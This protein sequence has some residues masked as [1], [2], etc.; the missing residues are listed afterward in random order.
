M[1]KMMK[2]NGFGFYGNMDE[3]NSRYGNVNGNN[4]GDITKCKYYVKP[5]NVTFADIAGLE[6]TK[7]EILEAID[8]FKTL[9][10]IKKWVYIKL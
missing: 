5:S 4:K 8:L 7:E 2:E 9:K 6:E 1:E 10:N 3:M